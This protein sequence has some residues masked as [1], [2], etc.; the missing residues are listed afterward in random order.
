MAHY[1][2]TWTIFM[3]L[4][5]YSYSTN[6][7]KM[8]SANPSRAAW[9][10]YRGK[11]K[12]N[13]L[14]QSGGDTVHHRLLRSKQR[15]PCTRFGKR[16]KRNTGCTNRQ[17][18]PA[19]WNRLCTRQNRKC[20]QSPWKLQQQNSWVS[21]WG[22]WRLDR[23]ILCWREW[24]IW[25]TPSTWRLSQRKPERGHE[26]LW[27]ISTTS[28]PQWHSIGHSLQGFVLQW[29]IDSGDACCSPQNGL[30]Q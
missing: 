17:P 10:I 26:L 30:W 14:I 4:G 9:K 25:W 6:K 20:T 13:G 16:W 15:T 12:Q 24:R 19:C 3:P 1:F 21:S 29:P 11:N 22:G 2:I 8:V 18:V 28:I 7:C 27:S 23:L 5:V